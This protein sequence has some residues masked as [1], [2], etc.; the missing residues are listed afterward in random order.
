L[1]LS[2]PEAASY[3]RE[4]LARIVD[5]FHLDLYRHDF[6]SPLRG[7]GSETLRGGFLESDYWR[8]YEAFFGAFQSLHA[9][10]PDL[11]L[12]QA[13]AGG[14]RLDLGTV[15]ALPENYTSDRVSFPH[16]YRMA[17]GLSTYLPPE[18]LVTPNGM[19]RDLPDTT[20]FLRGTYAIGNTP[21]I[22][23][24]VLPRSLD[25][26]RPE[27]R[28]LFDRYA[29]LYKTFIRPLLPTCRVY[30][31]DPVNATDGYEAGNWFAMQFMSPDGR[32]G[33]GTII[34]LSKNTERNY[35]FK[36]K[37]LGA[38]ATYTVTFDNTGK[39]IEAQ[40]ATLM[41]DGIHVET[42][43]AVASELLLFKPKE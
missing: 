1:N 19:S 18:I 12:Q 28:H 43:D 20:T 39:S 29:T 32:Q 30:H 17:A 35:L 8:H 25:E 40:G 22:F 10:H 9:T 15:G 36:P 27:T 23:N 3:F 2:I 13:S 38:S 37:G 26:F 5:Y 31:L 41:R 24:G 34:R 11:I 42:T 14:T 33:W 16:V 4:E 7:R 21:M 6:N